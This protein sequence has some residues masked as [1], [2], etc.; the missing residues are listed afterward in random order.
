VKQTAFAQVAEAWNIFCGALAKRKPP[1]DSFSEYSTITA[2]L[3]LSNQHQDTGVNRGPAHEPP[4]HP[5][6][7][8]GDFVGADDHHASQKEGE[9]A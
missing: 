3:R 6:A 9:Q 7:F 4:E 2:G 1:T 5:P 8:G